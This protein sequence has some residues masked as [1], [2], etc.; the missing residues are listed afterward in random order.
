MTT[1]I[2]GATGY[3][4]RALVETLCKSGA[5]P[6]SVI[7]H[8]RPESS[9]LVAMKSAFESLG[10]TVDT[11]PWSLPDMVRTLADQQPRVV[12]ALL[13][14]TKARARD[15]AQ[16]GADASYEAV[17]RDLTLRLLAACRDA[18]PNAVF[19]YLSSL[20]ANHRSSNGYLRIRGDV[21]VAIKSSGQPFIIAQPSFI[22]GSDRPESRPGERVAAAITNAGLGLFRLVGARNLANRYGSMTGH[23]LAESLASASNRA[24][25][26]GRTLRS[27]DLRR[28]LL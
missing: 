11:T 25:L 22:T 6:E 26:T 5:H 16:S 19:V 28:L 20:G 3:T 4:G 21:E 27:D 15:A 17:D 9:Q 10:A 12:F 18:C 8:I 1:F 24:E 7:A 23:E 13:G 2:A 14:T